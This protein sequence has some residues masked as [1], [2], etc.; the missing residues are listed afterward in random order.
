MTSRGP[1][2]IR[3]EMCYAGNNDAQSYMY[4]GRPP[5]EKRTP[6]RLRSVQAPVTKATNRV[7]KRFLRD[8]ARLPS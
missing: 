4:V 7:T 3:K 2:I 1:Q 6:I 8:L 5:P